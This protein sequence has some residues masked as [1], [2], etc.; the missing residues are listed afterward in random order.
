MFSIVGIMKSTF[1]LLLNHALT[2]RPKESKMPSCE[3]LRDKLSQVDLKNWNESANIYKIIYFISFY[4]EIS[5]SKPLS[6]LM[7]MTLISE[8]RS[9][10]SKL[11]LERCKMSVYM[12]VILVFYPCLT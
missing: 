10:V 11:I 9:V 7:C 5:S 4:P 2:K 1:I 3:A 6:H 12:L 8:S